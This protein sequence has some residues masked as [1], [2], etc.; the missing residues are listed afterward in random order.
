MWP[1]KHFSRAEFACRCG[2]GAAVVDAELLAVLQQLRDHYQQPITISSGHR[3]QAHNSTVGGSPA[4]QHLTGQA[5]DFAVNG[6]SPRAV[7]VHLD[8]LYP[9]RYGLGLYP[10]W[11]HLDVRWVAA[12]W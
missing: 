10:T 2:C 4:S 3:C 12:R 6:V 1:A 7:Y 5:A 11:I 9:R 8:R